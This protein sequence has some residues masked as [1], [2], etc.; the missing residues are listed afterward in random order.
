MIFFPHIFVSYEV[1]NSKN[2]E[3]FQYVPHLKFNFKMKFGFRN[4]PGSKK[5]TQ[6]RPIISTTLIGGFST[7]CFWPFLGRAIKTTKVNAV[8]SCVNFH[9]NWEIIEIL[10]FLFAWQNRKL[11][12]ILT[13]S[14]TRF[15]RIWK[16]ISREISLSAGKSY[17]LMNIV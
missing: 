1:Q 7:Q 10:E 5:S 2:W 14:Y 3:N 4:Y 9:C 12:Y 8:S 13:K 6:A 15:V 17:W 16:G 11:F